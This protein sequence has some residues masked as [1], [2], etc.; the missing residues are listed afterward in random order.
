M[1]PSQSGV[2]QRRRREVQPGHELS[3]RLVWLARPQE[4]DRQVDIDGGR[5]RHQRDGAL[6]ADPRA[7]ASPPSRAARF[8]ET[9]GWRRP[10]DR[11]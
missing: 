6:Q 3:E 2:G 5:R 7:A 4:R 9:H 10:L 8:R 11:A 1:A